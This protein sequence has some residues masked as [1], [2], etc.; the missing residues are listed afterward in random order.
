MVVRDIT[1]RKRVEEERVR[2][3]DQLE[4]EQERLRA[5][6]E[7]MPA[8]VLFAEAGTG[9]IVLANSHL[10]ELLG[11]PAPSPGE[12]F[13]QWAVGGP[14]ALPLAQ[15][16]RGETVRGEEYCQVRPD[17]SAV[18]L[19]AN[20][21]PVQDGRRCSPS[22][23]MTAGRPGAGRTPSRRPPWICRTWPSSNWSCPALTGSRSPGG[24]KP[25]LGRSDRCWSP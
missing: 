1:E 17:G 25:C 23:D 21:A 14:F 8:G 9:R 13:D 22:T 11:K 18:W 3:L 2:L 7:Q 19:R 20:A 24:C 10:T 5:V 15:A 12:D 6:L 16:L 4:T